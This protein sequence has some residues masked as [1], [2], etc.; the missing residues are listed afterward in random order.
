MASLELHCLFNQLLHLDFC[1][2]WETL[3]INLH[4]TGAYKFRDV[5]LISSYI[6]ISFLDTQHGILCKL[7]YRKLV[8]LVKI[9]ASAMTAQLSNNLTWSSTHSKYKLFTCTFEHC[10]YCLA[11]VL[12]F[13]K[14]L[15][16]LTVVVVVT[17]LT[18]S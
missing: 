5:W 7:N 10:V 1:P 4:L 16:K 13:L 9:N 8:I 17:S 2:V 12:L 6:T 3:L 14:A 15:S 18:S 11:K